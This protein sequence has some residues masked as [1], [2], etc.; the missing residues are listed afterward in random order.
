MKKINISG[1]DSGIDGGEVEEFHNSYLLSKEIKRKYK[2]EE[3][4]A[5]DDPW[6][7]VILI[8]KSGNTSISCFQITSDWSPGDVKEGQPKPT[9]NKKGEYE[10]HNLCTD[11]KSITINNKDGKMVRIPSKKVQ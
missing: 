10:G 6:A 1:Y 5:M 7:N 11:I 2:E 9:F 8:E 3:E 4:A